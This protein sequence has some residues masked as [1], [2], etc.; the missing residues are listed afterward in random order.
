MSPTSGLLDTSGSLAAQAARSLRLPG[1]VTGA[2]RVEE[3]YPVVFARGRGARLWDVDG[4]EYIDYHCGYGSAFLGYGHPVVD[5]A[6]SRAIEDDRSFVGCAHVYEDA[7]AERLTALLPEADKVAF[8]GGG[9]TDAL[10][11]A[12][13]VARSF[14]GRQKIVKAE[15]GY[16]GWHGVLG[17]STSPALDDPAKVALPPT[18]SN[19]SGTLPATLDAL[20]VVNVNDLDS[21]RARFELE[22]DEIAG[23]VL[24]PILYSAGVVGVDRE[25]LEL[26]RELCDRYGSVLVFDEVVSGFRLTL[27][28]AAALA[29]VMPDLSVYGKAIANGHVIA[30]LAGRRDLIDVLAPAGPAFYSGTFNGHP[31]ACAAVDA[32]LDVLATGEAF[33]HAT[34]LAK[35]TADG[36]GAAIA[37][38]G[39]IA[40]CQQVGPLWNLYFNAT[41][42]RDYRDLAAISDPAT[43]EINRRLR[44]HLRDRGI[45][46][47]HRKGTNRAFVSGAHTQADVDHTVEVIAGFLRTELGA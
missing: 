15:G 40:V 45:F 9:G 25:Y 13:R 10:Y 43:L 34:A 31:L 36:V 33:A 38:I 2:G 19:S 46:L 44:H 39:A 3:P 28:G 35:A 20:R 24:E 42:V 8:S 4:N 26:A 23:V 12:V 5:E 6:V 18:I 27:G 29:R 30:V 14:T 37:E 22:G 17:A 1:G 7:L 32:T 16:Q 11:N 41:E 21:L 47:Q